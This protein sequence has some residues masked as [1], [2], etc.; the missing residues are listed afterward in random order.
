MFSNH[1]STSKAQ[2]LMEIPHSPVSPLFP[3]W[4]QFFSPPSLLTSRPINQLHLKSCSGK[5]AHIW[6]FHW[7]SLL[8]C[9]QLVGQLLGHLGTTKGVIFLRFCISG[10]VYHKHLVEKKKGEKSDGAMMLLFYPK[11]AGEALPGNHPRHQSFPAALHTPPLLYITSPYRE[12]RC[13]SLRR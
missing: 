12:M 7:I 13:C 1:G 6:S 3:S 11:Q 9:G 8:A 2:N 4:P 10:F 5:K